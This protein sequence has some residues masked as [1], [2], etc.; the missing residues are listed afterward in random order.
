[1]RTAGATA[2]GGGV[3]AQRYGGIGSCRGRLLVDGADEAQQ[4]A[5][6]IG[7]DELALHDVAAFPHAVASILE[8]DEQ[9]IAC[10]LDL[11]CERIDIGGADLEVDAA[12][13]G[14]FEALKLVKDG[15][16]PGG[17]VI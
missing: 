10:S 9:R 5:V 15:A 3:G 8:R 2:F 11:G 16:A 1:V 14:P 13:E 17:G 4:V 12:A 6:G 7:D